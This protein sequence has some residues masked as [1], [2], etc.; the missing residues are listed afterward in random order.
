MGKIIFTQLG[1]NG[2]TDNFILTLQNHFK[3]SKTVRISVLKSARVEGI[4]GKKIVKKYSDEILEKLGK[5]YS[6]RVI[7]FVIVTKKK[8][9]S[10][11]LC[12]K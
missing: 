5:N 12:R 8:W 7:G 2:V 3:K 11:G 10:S 6:A 4:E 1:K 9:K